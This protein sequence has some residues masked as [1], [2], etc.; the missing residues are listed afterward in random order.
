MRKAL[1]PL[2]LPILKFA[3][4]S[5]VAGDDLDDALQICD[6]AASRAYGVTVCYWQ[7]TG[8]DPR[9]V[10]SHYDRAI[11]RIAEK[12]LDGHLA[13]K[14]PGLHEREDLVRAVVEHA[15]A[16]EVTAVFDAHG[17]E[18]VEDVF[19]AAEALGPRLL[20]MVI[21]GRWRRSLDDADRAVALGLRVRVVKGEFPGPDEPYASLREGYLAV[22]DRL[23]GR[24]GMVGVATHDA[25]LSREAIRRLQAAGT[26][27]EQELLFGMPFEPAAAEGRKA[28]IRTRIYVPYGSAW[29]PYSLSRA[30]K[31]PR[32]IGWLAR[33]FLA[34][35]AR[36]IP[37]PPQG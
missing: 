30:F 10:A 24:A 15:R 12:A 28:G 23:A 37:A 35:R 27:C 34:G 9:S 25:E 29:L 17:P 26:P 7:E 6:S 31:D 8:E 14:I 22:I 20:G 1:E 16:K 2:I 32:M 5:Y 33:D 18:K 21:P 13:V 19:T 4:R 11:D 36:E 3:T